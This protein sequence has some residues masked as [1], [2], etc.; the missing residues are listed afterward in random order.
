MSST[1]TEYGG[2]ATESYA[3]PATPF[4]ESYDLPQIEGPATRQAEAWVPT[5]TQTPFVTEYYGEAPG[6]TAEATSFEQLLFEMYSSEMNEA[7]AE[8]VQEGAALAAERA[9]ELGETIGGAATAEQFLQQWI[10]PVRQEAET[11]LS[12]VAEAFT[13]QDVQTMSESELEQMFERFEPRNTGLAPYFENFLGG[14]LKKGLNIVKGVVNM[15]KQGISSA[16]RLIPGLGPL[17]EKLKGLVKPLLDRVLKF[18]LDRL[19]PGLRPVAQRLARQLLGEQLEEAPIG[20]APA[21]AE[22]NWIQEQFDREAAQL[23]FAADEAQQEVVVNEAVT[24]TEQSESNAVNEL[25]EARARFVDEVSSMQRGQDPTPALENFLPAIMAV[26][27][28]VRTGISLIGRQNVVNFLAKY[29]AQLIQRYIGAEAA[30]P[31]SQAIVDTGLRML[32]LEAPTM[33]ETRPLA[34]AAIA[35]TIEDTVRRVAEHG[36]AVFESQALLEAVTNEAFQEA[37]AENFPPQLLR[38]EVHEAAQ[39]QATWVY[40]PLGKR[41]KYYK[42]YTRIFDV[43]L[44]PQMAESIKTFGG[45][46][47][48]AFLRDQLGVKGTVRARMHLYQATCGTWLSRISKFEQV[49]GLGSAARS[50]WSQIHP[51]TPDAAG[52]L[53]QQPRLG[54]RTSAKFLSNRNLIAVGQRFYYLEIPGARPPAPPPGIVGRPRSSQINLTLDF[55]KN[56]YRAF[57]YMS[58]GDA[59][60]V[61][62]ALRR[63]DIT[64]AVTLVRKIVNAGVRTVLG[65]R[66][67]SHIKVRHETPS[68]EQFLGAVLAKAGEI[69]LEVLITKLIE[70]IGRAIADYLQVRSDEFVRATQDQRY[71]VTIVVTL[72]NPPGSSLVRRALK[73]EAINPLELANPLNVF[74]GLPSLS[75][76]TVAGFRFD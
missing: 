45:T 4:L 6:M 74:R 35:G 47:L 75:A 26:L 32:T 52:T 41:R 66:L 65:G 23:L 73:G 39:V 57:V 38:P 44:T 18:A 3:P 2:V 62:A 29:L 76:A 9:E 17:L 50:A 71:G 25:Q 70:W 72:R 27:P 48:A 42:K 68:Q 43:E 12:N 49:P 33:T 24:E 20:E 36:E 67:R 19:P 28:L 58:E 63:K 55:P 37:A 15:A 53:L 40:M 7:I 51:L 11:M 61:A 30:T 22:V 60:E 1:E 13:Q 10:E 21:V 64:A 16:I 31:L 14:L 8:I 46:T 69:V 59:Q 54:R 34:G 56:E 5:G